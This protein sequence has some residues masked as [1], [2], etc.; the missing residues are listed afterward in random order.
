MRLEQ[1]LRDGMRSASDEQGRLR[2]A[3]TLMRALEK[4][5]L[6][7]FEPLE[8]PDK[9]EMVMSR[10]QQQVAKHLRRGVELSFV[11]PRQIA[12]TLLLGTD[13]QSHPGQFEALTG[14]F[15]NRCLTMLRANRRSPDEV[16][17]DVGS[18]VVDQLAQWIESLGDSPLQSLAR[19]NEFVT[20][21][22]EVVPNGPTSDPAKIIINRL[23]VEKKTTWRDYGQGGGLCVEIPEKRFEDIVGLESAKQALQ[24]MSLTLKNRGALTRAGVPP[25]RGALLWGAP[26]TAKTT[27]AKAM[28]NQAG[29]PFIAIT[30]PDLL[31][32]GF[33]NRVFTVARKHQPSIV[34]V[35]EIDALGRRG[36]GGNDV[37]INLLLSEIDGINIGA[38]SSVFVLAASNFPSKVDYALLRSGRI[39]CHIEIPTL[40]KPARTTYFQRF[41]PWAVLSNAELDELAEL[42]SGLS[43]ADLER[44]LRQVILV[45]EK[46]GVPLLKAEVVKDVVR[47]VSFGP[48]LTR[49]DAPCGK[50]L[51]LVA[52]HEAGHVIV[53]QTLAPSRRLV[54]VSIEPRKTAGRCTFAGDSVMQDLA[55]VRSDLASLLAGRV[56][57]TMLFGEAGM[58]SGAR[59]D[60]EAATAL[61]RRAIME[62]GLD[63]V[64]GMVHLASLGASSPLSEALRIQIE[65]RVVHWL[66]QAQTSATQILTLNVDQHMAL[67]NALLER[68]RLS[69]LE[70]SAL[71]EPRLDPD[72][73]YRQPP[74]RQLSLSVVPD[75][76]E[77]FG[78]VFDSGAARMMA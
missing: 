17:I 64:I 45:R 65:N 23:N 27:L 56:A 68:K 76:K 75:D 77:A 1:A 12:E 42:A 6:Y 35:D 73:S 31:Q 41:A 2:V 62:W 46:S 33:I 18:H 54:E 3:P 51:S 52:C 78:S 28:A 59:Q 36:Q 63:S 25:P 67:S 5:R 26:G 50:Y 15:I 34:F 14:G 58:G 16:L 57:E 74:E 48:L 20:F 19:R 71:L 61:A 49:T 4:S 37:A 32:P 66:E 21:E 30:G 9:V 72:E 70:V 13:A 43:G 38:E 40:D 60:F 55:T 24:E 53:S 22:L 44:C 10:L 29:L 69:G 39:E 11:Q 47:D 7:L 8:W